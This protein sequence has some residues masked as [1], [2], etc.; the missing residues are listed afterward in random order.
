MDDEEK[1]GIQKVFTGMAPDSMAAGMEAESRS[2][3][4]RCTYCGYEQSVWETG[5]VRY[6]ASG[7]SRQLRRCPNCGR[8]SW[9]VV[10]RKQGAP[11]AVPTTMPLA[12]P[13]RRWLLWVVGLG[14]P[15]ARIVAF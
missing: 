1:S 7:T 15:A 13:R 11:S 4:V 2:W 5:G 6:K 8:L 10:Y 12:N 3:M 14:S 9:H